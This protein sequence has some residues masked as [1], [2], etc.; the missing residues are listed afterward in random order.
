MITLI[1]GAV[2]VGESEKITI[3]QSQD[4][5]QEAHS[6]QVSTTGSPTAVVVSILGSIDG[7]NFTCILRHPFNK[8]EITAGTA[9][10]HLV[11]KPVPTIKAKI[12][13]LTGGVSP[14]VSV[15]YFKGTL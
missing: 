2:A 12:E 15:Y 4:T 1:D 13:T 10:F 8:K 11:N 14:T 7:V 5:G 9:L 3:T 6:F